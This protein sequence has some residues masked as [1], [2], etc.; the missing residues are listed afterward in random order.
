MSDQA[1]LIH[2]PG[3][4]RARVRVKICG[5][6]SEA[7][8]RSCV[9]SG[10]SYVGFVFY[11]AS[12]RAVA[13]EQAAALASA[14]PPGLDRVALFVNPDDDLIEATLARV[15]V[16]YLQLHGEETA[17]RGAAIRS[18]SGKPVI[19]AVRI[20]Q[21]ED[22]AALLEAESWADQLLCDAASPGARPGGNGE[23]FD[24]ERVAGRRWRRPWLLAG[25][26]TQNKLARAV[27]ITG[28]LQVD[29]SS[30]VEVEPGRKDPR[31]IAAF[32]DAAR[33]I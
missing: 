21:Q 16:D 10:A 19:K 2:A 13:L 14:T 22:L 18:R 3:P 8:I 33:A 20:G 26:L 24:W 15:P 27:R 7:D 23:A 12:P 25:G 11:P 9:E 4:A 29:V 6:R 1:S 28:A 31:K 32:L 5:V 30:G 17:E